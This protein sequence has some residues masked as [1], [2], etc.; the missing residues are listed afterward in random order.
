MKCRLAGETEVLLGENLP[1]RHFCPQNPTRP[2]PG[3]NPCRRGWE[4]CHTYCTTRCL[5]LPLFY[6]FVLTPKP[7]ETHDHRLF[8]RLNICGHS[9]YVT[10]FLT[11]GWICR[12][13]LLQDSRVH[14]LL[15]HI[16][17]CPSLEDQVSSPRN[18]VAQSNPQALGC[19]FIASYDSQGFGGG[20]RPPNITVLPRYRI[21]P[22]PVPNSEIM[23][24]V[25]S[26]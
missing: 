26:R 8:F 13:Q 12:L 18:T 7:F 10:S 22:V 5:P 11:R 2:D 23:N 3:L 16:R 14:K 17:Y 19:V 21:R 15:S 24:R 9:A 25:D 20:F 6:Q 1:Q 4:L